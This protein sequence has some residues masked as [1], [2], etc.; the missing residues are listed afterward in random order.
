MTA[1]VKGCDI[2]VAE[3]EPTHTSVCILT[4][5]PLAQSRASSASDYTTLPLD[6]DM[7]HQ[8]AGSTAMESQ[9]RHLLLLLK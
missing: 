1:T 4:H 8:K 9:M 5:G 7:E 2:I 6:P 3:R